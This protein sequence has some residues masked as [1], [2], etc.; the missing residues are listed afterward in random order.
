MS[1][2]CDEEVGI[3]VGRVDIL[4]SFSFVFLRLSNLC[5]RCIFKLSREERKGRETCKN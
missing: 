2:G 5:F 4:W 3:A 1:A